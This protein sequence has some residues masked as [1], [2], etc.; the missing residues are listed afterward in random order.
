MRYDIVRVKGLFVGV[1]VVEAECRT[2]VGMRITQSGMH[3]TVKAGL[4]I[5]TLRCLMLSG[6]WD[7]FWE[8]RT[9]A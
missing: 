8:S 3:W 9:T 2:V 7:D 4:N 1:G 5:A 6:L